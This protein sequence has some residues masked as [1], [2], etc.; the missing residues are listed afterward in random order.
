MISQKEL[1]DLGM[2]LNKTT[3]SL[4]LIEDESNRI[5]SAIIDRDDDL[6][7]EKGFFYRN[8]KRIRQDILHLQAELQEC[9]TKLLR[10]AGLFKG[11]LKK[12]KFS[13]FADSIDAMPLEFFLTKGEVDVLLAEKE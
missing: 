10:L 8:T 12:E 6:S 11:T 7:A 9:N 4:L 3:A 13:R 5:L 1:E 2:Y